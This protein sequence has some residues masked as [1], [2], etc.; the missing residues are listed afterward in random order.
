[1]LDLGVAGDRLKKQCPVAMRGVAFEAQKRA[2]LLF[3]QRNH[4][5]RLGDRLRKLELSCVNPLEIGMA[6]SSGGT[7]PFS[8]RSKRFEVTIFDACFFQSRPQR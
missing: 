5:R 6:S 1:M 4:L 3:R 2:G 8:R 7:T